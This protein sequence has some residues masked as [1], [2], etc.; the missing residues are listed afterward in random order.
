[1]GRPRLA[2]LTDWFQD[3]D[4][5]LTISVVGLGYIGLPT[6]AVAASRIRDCKVVGLD[7]S[8]EIVDTV[9]RGDVHIVEPGLDML[10]KG[11]VSEGR[12]RATVTPE[13]ADVF[14]IA[15]PTPFDAQRE[16]DLSCIEA[17][18]TNIAPVLRPGNLV[19]LESTS[20]VGATERM[21]AWLAKQRPDLAFPIRSDGASADASAPGAD[22]FVAHC[23]ERVLPGWV[24][25]EL[26][27]NDRV[28]GGV[29]PACTEKA[30]A[31]YRLFVRGKCVSTDART[32]EMVKLA[33]NAFRDVNIAYANELSTVC[34]DVGVN[35]WQLISL[36]NRHPRVNILQ[37]GCG[38]GGHCIAVDPWFIVH[39]SP[40][41][42]NLIRAAR[43]V[44]D[45]KPGY[46][47]EQVG[48]AI[49]EQDCKTVSCL[50]LSFKPNIDDMRESPALQIVES[51]VAEFPEC[52]FLAVE[53]NIDDLPASLRERANI[54]LENTVESAL[55]QAD[56]VVLLVDHREFFTHVD[57]LRG[58]RLIDT[59]GVLDR[60]GQAE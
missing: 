54:F 13:P 6:A 26:V 23:P 39:A 33:E 37:P 56:L 60:A 55:E 15:V 14:V 11:V 30:V 35:V 29:T 36:A 41:R 25:K 58:T 59:R 46:V 16:P 40:E 8:S 34:D 42:A 1:M 7:V 52:K 43:E 21:T 32:A 3:M 44:N 5:N 22:I 49:R 27:D 4:K 17:A 24:I 51:L 50:G 48:R 31:F 18:A 10:V 9:N 53:P 57:R 19:I 20:P 38:V 2:S 45:G 12:L 47:L 28:I